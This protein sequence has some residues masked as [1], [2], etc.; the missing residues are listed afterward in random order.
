MNHIIPYRVAIDM[1]N[2]STSSDLMAQ[3]FVH[4][5]A[6][7]SSHCQAARWTQGSRGDLDK[8]EARHRPLD[9]LRNSV[10]STPLDSHL[11]QCA[12]AICMAMARCT[13]HPTIKHLPLLGVSGVKTVRSFQSST[14][15]NNLNVEVSIQRTFFCP[16]NRNH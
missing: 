12:S 6:Q 14:S 15:L 9:L 8:W 7:P 13:S 2:L 10:F 3:D 1:S 11:W 16:S 5:A 4:L